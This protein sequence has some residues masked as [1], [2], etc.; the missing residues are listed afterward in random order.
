MDLIVKL[1]FLED[2]SYITGPRNDDVP[3]PHSLEAV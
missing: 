3:T 1:L 2:K